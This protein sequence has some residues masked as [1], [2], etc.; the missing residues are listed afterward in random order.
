MNIGLETEIKSDNSLERLPFQHYLSFL[1]S[2][3][4][5]CIHYW[6]FVWQV[7]KD[8]GKATSIACRKQH[9]CVAFNGAIN[10]ASGKFVFVSF[11]RWFDS[12]ARC[13]WRLS[14]CTLIFPEKNSRFKFDWLPRIEFPPALKSVWK[15]FEYYFH[16]L[17]IFSLWTF[18]PNNVMTSNYR[19]LLWFNLGCEGFASTNKQFYQFKNAAFLVSCVH[20]LI[21]VK[22]PRDISYSVRL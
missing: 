15:L 16:F 11:T 10:C 5:I 2:S 20:I 8:E 9:A 17:C 7:W 1:L 13:S 6:A 22:Y 21:D 4:H 18:W 3:A 14:V 12:P 19:L